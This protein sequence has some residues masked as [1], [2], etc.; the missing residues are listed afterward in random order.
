MIHFYFD[1]KMKNYDV[2]AL[3][4]TNNANETNQEYIMKAHNAQEN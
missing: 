3:Q 2:F 1:I 4:R